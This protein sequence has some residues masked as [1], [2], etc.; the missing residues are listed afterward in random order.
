MIMRKRGTATILVIEDDR[1]LREGL[2]MNFQL[3]GY[4]V[5][6]AADGDDGVRAAIDSEPDLIVLDIMLPGRSGLEILNE[7][8][9]MRHDVPVLIL[10][11]RDRTSEKA[12]SHNRIGGEM[13][14]RN[15]EKLAQNIHYHCK[16]IEKGEKIV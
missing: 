2:A 14:A 15:R 6:T 8:R 5:V 7:L 16:M 11:A 12:L 1:S 4:S 10:S 9:D 3:Q 13:A